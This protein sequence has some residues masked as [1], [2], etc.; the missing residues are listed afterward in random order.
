MKQSTE[1]EIQRL[2]GWRQEILLMRQKTIKYMVAITVGTL[3]AAACMVMTGC[4]HEITIL[5]L[6]LAFLILAHLLGQTRVMRF[7][8]KDIRS[9]VLSSPRCGG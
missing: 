6:V 9:Y 8:E 5:I 4:R 2:E 7:V 1:V 3:V